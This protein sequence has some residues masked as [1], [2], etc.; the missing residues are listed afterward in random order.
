MELTGLLGECGGLALAIFR[1]SDH[2]N[3]IVDTRFQSVDSIMTTRWQ[4]HVFKDGYTL[5]GCHNRDPVTSDGCGVERWPAEA[6]AGVAHLLEAEVRQ[7]WDF[8]AGGGR[9]GGKGGEERK[10]EDNRSTK[11][12]RGKGRKKG[13][14]LDTRARKRKPTDKKTRAVVKASNENCI[15]P[16][17]WDIQRITPMEALMQGCLSWYI[18]Y[19]TVRFKLLFNEVSPLKILNIY[20]GNTALVCKQFWYCFTSAAGSKL[21]QWC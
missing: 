20:T 7:L 3:V 12:T 21:E 11:Q 18:Y 9:I 15:L 17:G 8:C 1:H 2:T 14:W 4:N 5:A 19:F 13:K 16:V 10:R 6:D